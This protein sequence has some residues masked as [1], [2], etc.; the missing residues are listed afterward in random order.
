MNTVLADPQ[1]DRESVDQCAGA[2]STEVS[3][4]RCI[5]HLFFPRAL[6]DLSPTRRQ[7]S[8]HRSAT[9]FCQGL[10]KEVRRGL[11]LRD[12]T[13]A[14]TSNP[15]FASRSKTRNLGVGS[16]GSASRSCWTMQKEWRAERFE[17]LLDGTRAGRGREPV[18]ETQRRRF[19]PPAGCGA[20]RTWFE[21]VHKTQVQ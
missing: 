1:N 21:L 12:R 6:I 7:L 5:Q 16:N 4:L 2:I 14:G 9:P 17:T 20:R 15:Y 13:A 11:I 3:V 8:T 19:I 18:L 10:S